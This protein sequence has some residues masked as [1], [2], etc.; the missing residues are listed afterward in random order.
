[1]GRLARFRH[2]AE[3]GGPPAPRVARS[4]AAGRPGSLSSTL[5]LANI[6]LPALG[7]TRD[8]ALSVPT[9]A[10][11]RDLIVGAC[12]QMGV[13]RHRGAER[14]EPGPLLTQPDPDTT[15]AA[16]IAGTVD[17]L[18]F[19]GRAYWTVL[20]FDG[21]TSEQ[22]PEGFPIRARWFP[23]DTVTAN[24]VSDG[25]AY[26]RLE[27]YTVQGYE[28]E[29]PPRMV[30]RF[31]AALPGVLAYGGR[32]IQTAL[33]IE[34]AA[35]RFSDVDIPAGTLTNQGA[36]LSPDESDE[37]VAEFEAARA[38]H[39]VAWLQS[40]TYERTDISPHDLQL[41]DARAIAATDC[42]R[43]F[44]VPVA[45]V[46]ASPSGNATAL[47]YQNLDATLALFVSNAVAPHLRVLEQTLSLPSVTPR[48]QA[49]AF[50]VQAFLRSDPAAA[51]KYALD[52]YAADLVSR[53][54]ARGFLGIPTTTADN[55][56][57]PGSVN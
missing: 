37:I 6:D 35:R 14:L 55:A 43:L 7:V 32:T 31:D 46:G 21:A 12:V 15:W 34:Q 3:R 53:D 23:Y 33:A 45:M 4:R 9:V 39:S 48:G 22:N 47:L 11:C 16:T 17:D 29:L 18:I 19:Y 50:D 56:L 27:S 30:I 5:E 13:G 42:T 51:A 40:V 41:I 8:L 36:E 26:S 24:V 20:A 2:R 54:E 52:L 38:N 49:V 25:G 28:S 1:M 44:N 57:Q 10:A